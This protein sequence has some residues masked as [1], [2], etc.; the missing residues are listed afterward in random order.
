[1]TQTCTNCPNNNKKEH[2]TSSA[3]SG[4]VITYGAIHFLAFLFAVYLSFKCH[5]SFH[6]PSFIVALFC[7]WIYIVW[8][9]A[10]KGP[11]MCTNF[12]NGHPPG[13]INLD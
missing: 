2:F 4:V 8:V 5:G 3:N 13:I 10:T 6:L 1:M 11:K 9:F 7:P 12:T